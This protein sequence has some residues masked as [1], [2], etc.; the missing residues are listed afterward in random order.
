M[1][2]KAGILEHLLLEHAEVF[3]CQLA[4]EELLGEARIARVFVAVLD[5]CHAAVELFACDVQRLTEI[6]G[7]QSALG[8]VHD[9]HNVVGWLVEY[10]QLAV[11]VGDD[12]P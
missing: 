4:H 1:Y 11:A 7:V 3:L 5:G 2:V 10:Q 8:F 12:A 6:K 9:H